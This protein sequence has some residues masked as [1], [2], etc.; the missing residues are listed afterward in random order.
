MGDKRTT[1]QA[2]IDVLSTERLPNKQLLP[3]KAK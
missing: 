1:A 2:I 3:V